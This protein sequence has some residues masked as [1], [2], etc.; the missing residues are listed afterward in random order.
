Q[1]LINGR[2]PGV[3]ILPGTGQAGS[4]S[5]VRIRGISSLSLLNNPLL[6]VDGIRVDND[7]STGPNVQS[8]GSSVISRLNDYDPSDIQSIEIIEGPSAATLYG[9]EAASGVISIIT[10]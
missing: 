3:E 5:K 8:F 1:S 2:A 7:Q 9:T 6:Y 10:K 4:G